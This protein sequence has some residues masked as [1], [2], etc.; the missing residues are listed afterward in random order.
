MNGWPEESIIDFPISFDHPAVIMTL[1]ND[2]TT[3]D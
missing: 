1:A 3:T 2:E